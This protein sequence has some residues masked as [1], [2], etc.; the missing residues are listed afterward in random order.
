MAILEAQPIAIWIADPQGR[1]IEKN[2]MADRVWGGQAPLSGSIAEYSAYQGW[3]ADTG[4]PLAP[5]DW[6]LA[7]AVRGETRIGDIV[8]IQRFDGKRA[9]LLDSAAP[10]FDAQGNITTLGRGGSDTTGVALAAAL[11]ADECQIYTD[12]DGVYTTDPRIV[13]EARKLSTITFE[14]MLELASLG[15]KVLQIRSVEF[16]KRYHVPVHVRSSFNDSEGTWVVEED[17]SM[18]EVSVSGVALDRDEAAAREELRQLRE[19]LTRELK[20]VRA[21]LSQL[22][23]PLLADLGLPGCCFASTEVVGPGQR[24]AHDAGNLVRR[25]LDVMTWSQLRDLRA[26]GW[27]IG[28][29][30]GSHRRLSEC[31]RHALE[32]EIVGPLAVLRARLGLEWPPLAYPFGGPND[33]SA[34][35]R[36]LV[37]TSGY[38]ACFSNFGGENFPGDDPFHLKRIEI[39]GDHPTIAWKC[40][41]HGIDFRYWRRGREGQDSGFH[42]AAPRRPG[43]G[44]G[45]AAD[46]VRRTTTLRS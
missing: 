31:D 4:E 9:T 43:Q 22:R 41:V 2:E 25:Y 10:I 35:A 30:G 16:A 11:K 28:G 33:I 26:S 29:H 46:A 20:G 18:E 44:S 38:R 3:W 24:F 17:S 19:V 14:E 34:A 32:Q 5:E 45:R 8:D 13:P 40:R 42:A 1:I 21:Y 39:G 15:S 36:S 12:A 23:P 27:S 7:R 37:R 6:P